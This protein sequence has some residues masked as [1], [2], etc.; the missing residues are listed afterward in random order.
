MDTE[1]KN[2]NIITDD[3][4]ASDNLDGDADPDLEQSSSATEDEEIEATEFSE[5]A[6]SL[7]PCEA[8][9]EESKIDVSTKKRQ[10]TT[11]AKK[12]K[13][14]RHFYNAIRQQIEFYFSDSN[15]SKDRFLQQLISKSSDS[16]KY[17]LIFSMFLSIKNANLLY[18]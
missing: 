11:A 1:N 12:R 8:N 10:P 3:S 9:A 18:L 6:T 7:Q 4:D 2:E 5:A 14:K 15:L 13:R 17:L 16:S